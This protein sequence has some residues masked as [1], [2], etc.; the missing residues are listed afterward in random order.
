MSREY[1]SEWTPAVVLL[2]AP[3]LILGGVFGHL[4][5]SAAA[6]EPT[7]GAGA[8]A[9]EEYEYT[10]LGKDGC[11]TNT[12]YDTVREEAP[13]SFE[14]QFNRMQL[15]VSPGATDETPADTG[16]DQLHFQWDHESGELTPTEQ[17]LGMFTT[18]GRVGIDCS[19]SMSDA[20]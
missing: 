14:D 6:H 17:T 7:P 19:A 8:A 2:G 18:L 13:H 1:Y 4:A 15:T 5:I 12:A 10:F 11:L 9:L 16:Q 20:Q 3:T